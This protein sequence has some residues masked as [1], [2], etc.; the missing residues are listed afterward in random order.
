MTGRILKIYDFDQTITKYHTFRNPSHFIPANNTKKGIQSA[1]QHDDNNI[2][3]IA[4][5]H[6]NSLYV[7]RYL[8]PLLNLKEQDICQMENIPCE[9]H[10]LTKFY[11]KDKKHP[12]IISTVSNPLHRSGGKNHALL[13]ITKQLPYCNE[14]HFYDDDP[15]NTSEANKLRF[16]STHQVSPGV[17]FSILKSTPA[18]RDPSIGILI[19]YLQSYKAKRV[20]NQNEYSGWGSF[21]SFNL[22]GHSKTVK[23]AAVDALIN[24]LLTGE[25]LNERHLAPL[26]EGELAATIKSWQKVSGKTW[27]ELVVNVRSNRTN[28]M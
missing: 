3:A 18:S 28:V 10:T 13:D 23:I 7:L 25:E 6:N 12:I 26:N 27:P 19:N 15:D 17:A 21:F 14:Y 4:T 9:Q 1:I 20:S 5:Y 22:F 2:V 8:M 16:F 24:T 11:F